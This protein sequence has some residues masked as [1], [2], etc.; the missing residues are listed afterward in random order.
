MES[1]KRYVYFYC[2]LSLATAS[3]LYSNNA[4]FIIG[5]GWADCCPTHPDHKNGPW[6]Y[7]LP[8]LIISFI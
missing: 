4:I 2:L 1:N 3:I 6:F 7:F 8:V 5:G